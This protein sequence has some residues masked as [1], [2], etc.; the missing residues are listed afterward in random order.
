MAAL[1]RGPL[2]GRARSARARASA[3]SEGAG[4]AAVAVPLEALRVSILALGTV[5]A[6]QI[7]R[8]SEVGVLANS[9]H[10]ALGGTEVGSGVLAL[11]TGT[12]RPS[13]VGG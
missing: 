7:V 6:L 11:R 10:V 1:A 13:V 8:A 2:A 5:E 9:A 4:R 12:A 3:M